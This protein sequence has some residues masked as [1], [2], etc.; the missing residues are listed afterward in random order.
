MPEHLPGISGLMIY[1][2]TPF[3]ILSAFMSLDYSPSLA[4]KM[5]LFF[6]ISLLLQFSFILIV[7]FAFRKDR[8]RL[9]A[10]FMT[11]GSSLGN[12]GF[13]GLPLITALMPDVPEAAAYVTM[14]M[15]SMNVITFTYGIYKL[16]GDKK[17]I[18]LKSALINPTLLGLAM[19][20]HVFFLGLRGYI[21]SIMQ[22]AISLL[23]RMATPLCMFILGIRLCSIK[24]PKL[25]IKPL[26]FMICVESL[27]YFLSSVM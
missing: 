10:K 11:V 17:F 27:S 19:A 15:A 9:R 4:V 5:G 14:F 16:T 13:F 8:D 24:S 25:I 6:L 23:G 12:V 20:L 1:I 7:S 3:L 22:E 26:T 2:V 21:P 18:S